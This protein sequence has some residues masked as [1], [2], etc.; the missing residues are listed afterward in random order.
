[1][2]SK[3]PR[4]CACG[5]RIPPG[6]LCS[7]EK[8]RQTERK[9]RADRN[10]PSSSARGYSGRWERERANF[11]DLHPVCAFCGATASV[12][13]HKIPHRGDRGLFWRKSNWQPLCQKCHS[14]TKQRM[15]RRNTTR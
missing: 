6:L 13:D 1:M 9:A 15:E 10:R 2:P 14:S 5:Y 3:G 12:V 7:C 4:A 11:L 8:K